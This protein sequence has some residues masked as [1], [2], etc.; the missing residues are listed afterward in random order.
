MKNHIG[1]NETPDMIAGTFFITA[2]ACDYTLR[3]DGHINTFFITAHACDYTLRVEWF[4]HR[5][6]GILNHPLKKKNHIGCNETPAMIAGPFF[7]A[8]SVRD[9]TLRS[10]GHIDR[11]SSQHPHGTTHYASNAY[12]NPVGGNKPSHVNG[13]PSPGR[14]RDETESNRMT[15]G[16]GRSRYLTKPTTKPQDG[17]A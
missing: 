12:G 16:I 7:I 17:P 9:Y 6:P 1:C 2:H 14:Y 4:P 5:A 11:F 8:T 3:S 10:D 13:T 15:A